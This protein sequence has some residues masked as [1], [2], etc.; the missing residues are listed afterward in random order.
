MLLKRSICE[1]SP[2]S[3]TDS[4]AGWSIHYAEGPSCPIA[5]KGLS[6]QGQPIG[7]L[8]A[9]WAERPSEHWGP[10]PICSPFPLGAPSELRKM[11][12][13]SHVA[14]A[15]VSPS[16][17]PEHTYSSQVMLP[18]LY[19]LSSITAPSPQLMEVSTLFQPPETENELETMP[20]WWELF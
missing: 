14:S 18:D 19:S 16:A 17:L 13:T 10:S 12:P 9:R 4:C 15:S 3:N 5:L 1:K 8:P 6:L 7:L 11:V 2:V 20:S